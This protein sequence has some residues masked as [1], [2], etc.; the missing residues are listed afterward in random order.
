[1]QQQDQANKIMAKT[2][3]INDAAQQVAKDASIQAQ[4]TQE[5]L[6]AQRAAQAS[7]NATLSSANELN[8]LS[9]S[10]Q[11]NINSSPVKTQASDTSFIEIESVN[12]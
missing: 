3:Q 9:M 6:K 10:L 1:M 7:V 12:Y 11:K 5:L 4:K 2:N 8:K